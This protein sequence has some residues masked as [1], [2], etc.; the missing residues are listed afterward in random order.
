MGGLLRKRLKI[1]W[2][3]FY[4]S[5]KKVNVA[6]AMRANCP[7]DNAGHVLN[8]PHRPFLHRHSTPQPFR[9]HGARYACFFMVEC[10][11]SL[12]FWHW[13]IRF[14]A[15]SSTASTRATHHR[16]YTTFD[17]SSSPPNILYSDTG[18]LRVLR[19]LNR[20]RTISAQTI[21]AKKIT[22]LVTLS[23]TFDSTPKI[24][25]KNITNA[26]TARVPKKLFRTISFIFLSMLGG[27]LNHANQIT[28]H[29]Y[30]SRLIAVTRL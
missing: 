22:A 4:V 17:Y 30:K 18:G 23:L 20:L 12:R 14:S 6:C 26:V 16:L 2:P 19:F 27:V 1:K 8:H 15:D 24:N 5:M 29:F 11:L 10:F 7:E 3:L 13:T 28:G 9:A 21:M 25:W